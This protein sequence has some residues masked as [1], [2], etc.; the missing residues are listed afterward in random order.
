MATIMEM[1]GGKPGQTIV[2]VLGGKNG[3][4]IAQLVKNTETPP[5]EPEK[6]EKPVKTKKSAK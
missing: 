6:N 1:L 4:T 2:E 3:Q 5:V